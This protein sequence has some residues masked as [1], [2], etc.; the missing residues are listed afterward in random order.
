MMFERFGMSGLDTD[1]QTS[2]GDDTKEVALQTVWSSLELHLPRVPPYRPGL[3]RSHSHSSNCCHRV[4]N[5]HA[6]DTN[7][8]MS[9][10]DD[11][12]GVL[13]V[14][15]SAPELQ[16]PRNPPDGLKPWAQGNN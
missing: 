9:R 10:G 2:L 8:Q 4:P 1:D 14:Q 15:R 12:E 13:K 6:L 5:M 7:E 16:L 3:P 11:T